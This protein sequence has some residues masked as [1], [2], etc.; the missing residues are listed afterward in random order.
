MNIN[1]AIELVKDTS[2]SVPI[3]SSVKYLREDT[4]I[5]IISQIDTQP[6]VVIP[7]FVA[8]WYDY[9]K[10]QNFSLRQALERWSM[11]EELEKWFQYSFNQNTFARAW[12]DGYIVE[13]EREKEQLYVV[14]D[15]NKLYLKQFDELNAVIVIDDVVGAT[16]YARR[17]SDK[18]EAQ[19]AADELGWIVKEI[20]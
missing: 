13:K 16:D 8:D 17:Y 1:E 7:K 19:K 3:N 18:T 2:Y 9:A 6:K 5:N 11:S 10:K 12:L 14:T 15:G 20:E 4:V